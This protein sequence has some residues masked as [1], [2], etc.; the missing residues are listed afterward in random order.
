VGQCTKNHKLCNTPSE[1]TPALPCRVIDIGS[2][3]HAAPRLLLVNCGTPLLSYTTLS[4]CWGIHI[5]LRLL[6]SN[7]STLEKEIP[8]SH[9]SKSF[10]D[11]LLVTRRLGLRCL[12]IDSL[13]VIQD[14]VSDWQEQS[15]SMAQI[16]SKSYCNIAAAHS[17]DGTQGCFLERNSDL[18]IP[19]KVYLDWGL[20]PGTYYAVQ[21]LYWRQNVMETLV[22]G[23][24][25]VCQERFLS[26]R[27]LYFGVRQL[28]WECCEVSASEYF[29]RGLPPGVGS[30]GLKG[31]DPHIDGARSR[32]ELALPENPDLDVFS[33]WNPV[34]SAYSMAKLTYST[35]KLVA[36][37]GL[38][39]RMQQ[40]VFERSRPEAE[41]L[42]REKRK[43]SVR[44]IMLGSEDG[45]VY[46]TKVEMIDAET[47]KRVSWKKVWEDL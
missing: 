1:K 18:V 37:S 20:H 6:A 38:A 13:C 11:T 5:P 42:C 25:W 30:P 47:R 10:Q 46:R 14:S 24:A 41:R 31:L 43:G 21:W 26:S 34:V 9:L 12:W 36:I 7:V 32:K 39:A 33:L 29:P 28:Y 2:D 40:P 15:A 19:L 45:R 3:E 22:I 4:H 35:D 16:Y 8:V 17:T 27:I 23:R 44:C